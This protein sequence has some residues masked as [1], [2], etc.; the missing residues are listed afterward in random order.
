MA[1]ISQQQVPSHFYNAKLFVSGMP[2]TIHPSKLEIEKME[3]VNEHTLK[4]DQRRIA[5]KKQ[6]KGEI[7]N[8]AFDLLL[9][10]QSISK[11]LLK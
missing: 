6:V 2:E 1:T 5:V 4:I 3:K 7:G 9:N 8:V 10:I 11:R